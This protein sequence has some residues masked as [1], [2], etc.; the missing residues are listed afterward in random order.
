MYFSFEDEILYNILNYG[1]NYVYKYI[2]LFVLKLF[3][4]KATNQIN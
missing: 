1:Y 4:Y 3:T 2:Q